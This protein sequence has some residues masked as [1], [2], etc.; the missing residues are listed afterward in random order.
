M[1]TRHTTMVVGPTGAGKSVVINTLKEALK[2]HTGIP[3]KIEILNPK[4]QTVPELYGVLDP[5]TRDWTDGLL[6]KLFRELNEEL[7]PDKPERRWIL[8]D[9]DVDALWVE[10]MNSV[11]DDSKILTLTNGERIRLQKYCAMLYEVFDLQYASPATISRCG[12][13]YVDP[14]NL[15]YAPFFERWAK[16][17]TK[18][19]SEVMTDSLMD[20]YRR[21]VPQC[22]E[23]VLEGVTG[24][25][26]PGPPLEFITPRTNLNLVTQFCLLFDSILPEENPPQEVDQIENL[27]IFCIVWSIGGSLQI[28][29][30]PKFDEFIRK[31][32]GR[33][34]P[35]TSLF[36]NYFDPKT[37]N[38]FPW[39]NVVETFSP[40]LDGKFS[41]ILV[42][43]IDT[44]RYS[45]LLE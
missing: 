36:D 2:A 8:Y 1:L 21:F 41:S 9:G 30:R 24:D 45:W 14:K 34:L 4:A 25:E 44:K 40:P 12:M 13:V 11:M 3:T 32:A 33:I 27:F 20:L 42:P 37:M 43:T 22:I 28:Q 35:N 38:L 23:Y 7:L 39:E 18:T 19:H 29:E 17:K 16:I 10:N 31:I 6:S 5:V 26:A 15:G